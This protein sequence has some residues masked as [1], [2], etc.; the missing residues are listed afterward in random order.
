MIVKIGLF[1]EAYYDLI[2]NK[3]DAKI[4]KWFMQ[5]HEKEEDI[6]NLTKNHTVHHIKETQNFFEN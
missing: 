2:V 3:S 1:T 6:I 4:P 5:N